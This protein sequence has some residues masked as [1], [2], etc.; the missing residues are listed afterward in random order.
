MVM[1][2]NDSSSSK[3]LYRRLGQAF[4]VLLEMG[5]VLGFCASCADHGTSSSGSD[6]NDAGTLQRN[7][8]SDSLF[9]DDSLRTYEIWVDPDSLAAIDADPT[10]EKWVGARSLVIGR[11]TIGPVGIRYKGNE[12]AWWGCTSEHL[13]GYKT[14]DKLSMKIKI[15]WGRDTTFFGMKKIQLHSMNTYGDQL[16]ER[17]GY[18]FFRRMGVAA[19][20]VVHVRL[21]VN[22]KEAGLF[23]HVEEIDG[24]FARY[25][26][27]DG[28]GNLYKE[29]WP[30]YD[31]QAQS[32]A[33]MQKGLQT[34]EDHG[35]VSLFSSFAQEL[36]AADSETARTVVER[37]QN[38]DQVLR[39]A[40]VSYGLD[41]DD[42][43][44][45]WYS[46]GTGRAAYPHNFF[47]YE[48][49]ATRKVHLIPW[50]VDH[51]LSN[52]ANPDTMNAVELRDGWGEISNNC[53]EFGQGW[54]QMSAACDKLVATWVTF[55]P[56]YRVIQQE[57]LDGPFREIDTVL[58]RWENQLRP[59]TAAIHAA[60]ERFVSPD[61]WEAALVDLHRELADA[62]KAIQAQLSHGN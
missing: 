4:L 27:A 29:V 46:G 34:N 12:G 20:R 60:D 13:S 42:G 41:D 53:Q 32:L 54:P 3:S 47:F 6:G 39:V 58:V 17:V 52:V 45:H 40:A 33:E 21:K 59:V 14:C 36:A 22:G 57:M 16:R 28:T 43:L 37:W 49:P 55:T 1:Q 18:W 5:A 30:L 25:H 24:R 9:A 26:F 2:I 11:D 50:D 48:E 35:D 56:R 7:A 62:Q 10:A 44:F 19:P 15:N 23:A 51:M 61:N 38:I 8:L 31:N